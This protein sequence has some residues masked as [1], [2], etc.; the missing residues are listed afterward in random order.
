MGQHHPR[1]RRQREPL[2][3]RRPRQP[4][5]SHVVR[6]TTTTARSQLMALLCAPIVARREPGAPQPPTAAVGEETTTTSAV[7]DDN[8]RQ[9]GGSRCGVVSPSLVACVQN[10][11]L[12]RPWASEWVLRPAQA[13]VFALR[14]RAWT[15]GTCWLWV[16]VSPT[17]GLV[18]SHWFRHDDNWSYVCGCVG[19]GSAVLVQTRM[20]IAYSPECFY[21]FDIMDVSDGS[22]DDGSS[23]LTCAAEELEAPFSSLCNKNWIVSLYQQ[24]EMFAWK[25]GSDSDGNLVLSEREGHH[26]KREKPAQTIRF[27]PLSDDVVVVVGPPGFMEFIDL[28]ESFIRG[29]LITMNTTNALYVSSM[30]TVTDIHTQHFQMYR[31][32]TYTQDITVPVTKSMHPTTNSTVNSGHPLAIITG[33]INIHAVCVNQMMKLVTR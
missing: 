5:D 3:T 8:N 25:V 13:A 7:I 33:T 2:E 30:S 12:V 28:E 27:S 32:P 21:Y 15:E 29:N 18:S 10:T 26:F 9:G 19:R 22:G 16:S 1:L 31:C 4:T 23:T 14:P 6:A 17:L 11:A 20:K 24:L